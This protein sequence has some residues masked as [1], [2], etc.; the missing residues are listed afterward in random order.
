M[1]EDEVKYKEA[2][3]KIILF[4]GNMEEYKRFKGYPVKVID[5]T[6]EDKGFALAKDK[7]K[8]VYAPNEELGRYM[9]DNGIEA[10]V[11]ANDTLSQSQSATTR[12]IYGLPV[13]RCFRGHPFLQSFFGL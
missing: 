13:R 8:G 4:P 3:S 11:N 9:V 2:L 1:V 5:T 10:I 12:L 7:I 6:R